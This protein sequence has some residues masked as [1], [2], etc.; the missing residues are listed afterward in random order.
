MNGFLYVSWSRR[1]VQNNKGK[2]SNI[3]LTPEQTH[4]D[5]IPVWLHLK[6]PHRTG[7]SSS[8]T[9]A[10][11]AP[12]PLCICGA[13]TASLWWMKIPLV[14]KPALNFTENATVHPN[15][16]NLK[17]HQLSQTPCLM[18][19]SLETKTM[20]YSVF[21]E[22]LTLKIFIQNYSLLSTFQIKFKQNGFLS[23]K[24][25]TWFLEVL[26]CEMMLIF[27]SGGGI[28]G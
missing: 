22:W 15:G 10:A 8:S 5:H 28:G 24:S 6:N 3:R 18:L 14:C 9:D 2:K 25:W 11:R 1:A 16:A 12:W 27:H 20:F 13:A 26:S 7:E 21:S 23:C 4:F 19:P 17:Q